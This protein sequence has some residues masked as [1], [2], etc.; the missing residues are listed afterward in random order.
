MAAPA[1]WSRIAWSLLA[2]FIIVGSAGTWSPY[3]PGLWAP[4]LISPADVARNIALYVP[5]GFLGMMALGRSD[6]R[7]VMRVTALAVLFSCANEVLQ[8]YTIDRIGSVTDVVSAAVGTIAGASV[9]ALFFAP[10]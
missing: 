3:Q 7:G 10:R 6:V 5:F 2:L 9:V 8:L 1:R 4:L